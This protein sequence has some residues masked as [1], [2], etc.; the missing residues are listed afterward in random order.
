MKSIKILY[1][2]GLIATTLLLA[3]LEF[4]IVTIESAPDSP[5]STYVMDLISMVTGVGGCFALLYCFRSKIVNRWIT[6]QPNKSEAMARVHT[7]RLIAWIVL[8]TANIT[9]YYMVPFAHNPKY[10]IVFLY[11]AVVFCW[12]G[13]SD[14]KDTL[15]SEN[16]NK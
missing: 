15:G 9:M 14:T 6:A 4:G 12:P 13:D 5:T 7:Y 11:I 8:T 10:A 1:V 16:T 2:S 3:L